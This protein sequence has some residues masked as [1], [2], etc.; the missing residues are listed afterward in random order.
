MGPETWDFCRG[1]FSKS[2]SDR[3]GV[4]PIT[5]VPE[6]WN[7]ASLDVCLGTHGV[8]LNFKKF[9]FVSKRNTC[10]LSSEVSP[11]LRTVSVSAGKTFSHLQ[12]AV[13]GLLLNS[14]ST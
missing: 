3:P 4:F 13:E 5:R 10:F 11:V 14:W 7:V 1:D 2:V 8:S 6:I 9:F 12:S